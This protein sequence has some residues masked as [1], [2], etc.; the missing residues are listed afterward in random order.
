[1]SKKDVTVVVSPGCPSGVGPELLLKAIDRTETACQIFWTGGPQ[2]LL[3]SAEIA[4]VRLINTHSKIF[5]KSLTGSSIICSDRDEKNLPEPGFPSDEGCFLQQHY[6]L[7]AITLIQ[8]EKFSALVTGPVRKKALQNVLGHNFPGQTELLNHFFAV[9]EQ[10]SL[11]CFSGLDFI[12][13]LASVHV[14]LK[15][16]AE[17]LTPQVLN[18]AIEKLV[19]AAAWYHQL[20]LAQIRLS[21][22]G[23]NPH[24]SENGLLGTED[25]EVLSPVIRVWQK[26][27]LH[28]DGP[29]A[30]DGF[31]G[32][33]RYL[34]AQQKPHA[35]LAMYHD[36]GLAPYKALVSDSVNFTW[37]LKILRT[38]PGHGTADA[39]AGKN[40]ASS[41]SCEQ[42]LKLALRF[43]TYQA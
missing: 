30:A 14:P 16:V 37:G 12:L 23:I 6:L 7:D 15:Q 5:F 11:M 8:K 40:I 25:L 13:G 19:Q 24:A 42:A 2:L 1:M 27:G 31:F 17:L 41:K 20:P 10:S 43:A 35:V 9:D 28:I 3:R 4:Q 22:L 32:Q 21:V 29:V 34:K 26:K 33:L 18:N 38:S 39:L 36:Q